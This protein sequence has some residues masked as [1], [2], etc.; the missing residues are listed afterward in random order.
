MFELYFMEIICPAEICI[1]LFLPILNRLFLALFCYKQ[2]IMPL[3]NQKLF[4]YSPFKYIVNTLRDRDV[5]FRIKKEY[6]NLLEETD[7]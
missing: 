2:F 3:L 4:L 1:S 6:F 5:M 7:H